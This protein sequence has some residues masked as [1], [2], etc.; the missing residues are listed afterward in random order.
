[1][2]SPE[3]ERFLRLRDQLSSFVRRK[4][5]AFQELDAQ[6][7]QGSAEQSKIVSEAASAIMNSTAY[8]D[9]E[10]SAGVL[11]PLLFVNEKF[12]HEVNAVVAMRALSELKSLRS[13]QENPATKF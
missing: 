6:G 9:V 7:E 1:M 4:A 10:G 5:E 3:S 13:Q 2:N 8:L 11:S 12:R